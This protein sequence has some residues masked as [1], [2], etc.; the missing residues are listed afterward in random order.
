MQ[1]LL[2]NHDVACVALVI[3]AGVQIA[4]VFRERRG[5]DGDSQTMPGGD[6]PGGEPQIDVVL[7]DLPRLEEQGPVE[8]VAETRPHDAV[9]DALC[10]PVRIDMLHHDIPVRVLPL[11]R[12]PESRR[13]KTGESQNGKS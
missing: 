6:H 10:T 8:A 1:N 13:P 5:G 9:L 4:V 3:T 2:P 7:V 12:H 11:S